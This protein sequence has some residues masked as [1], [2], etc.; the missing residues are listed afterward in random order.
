MPENDSDGYP[1]GLSFQ[2]TNNSKRV[3]VRIAGGGAVGQVAHSASDSPAD[4]RRISQTTRTKIVFSV[5]WAVYLVVS[6]GLATGVGI[7]IADNGDGARVFA[8]SG[9][10]P[11]SENG[12]AKGQGYVVTDFVAGSSRDPQKVINRI[13]TIHYP[14][15]N[16]Y[17]MTSLGVLSP[18]RTVSLFTVGW[19]YLII[20]LSIIWLVPLG[21]GLLPVGVIFGA[22]ALG[23]YARWVISTYADTPAF[24]GMAAVLSALV[25]GI[26]SVSAREFLQLNA[27][28]W[29]GSLLL[30][31]S[32]PAYGVSVPFVL[33]LW[34]VVLVVF[35]RGH[36]KHFLRIPLIL[37]TVA[38]LALTSLVSYL[39]FTSSDRDEAGRTNSYQFV[40]DVAMPYLPQ[41][42]IDEAIPANIQAMAPERYWPRAGGWLEVEGWQETFE[43]HSLINGLRLQVLS[44]PTTA[45]IIVSDTIVASTKPDISYTPPNTWS[46]PE[47]PP[48]AV[49]P[50]AL[51]QGSVVFVETLLIPMSFAT[52]NIVFIVVAALLALGLL[53][54][55]RRWKSGDGVSALAGQLTLLLWASGLFGGFFAGAAV[56]GDGYQEL[57]KHAILSSYMFVI[58]M[59]SLI[60]LIAVAVVAWWQ[61][62]KTPSMASPA[63]A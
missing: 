62:K 36:L 50:A 14:T 42:V 6:L 21:K 45:Y 39:Q 43:N 8:P 59:A 51:Y 55:V 46:T 5:V 1:S 32:K 35:H 18:D 49:V 4:S 31:L 26:R 33:I 56:L 9:V 24:F 54:L 44:Q 37:I 57:A 13:A 20:G 41:D 23:P 53:L 40:L 47:P 58:F 60:G 15:L 61:S 22:L 48:I 29:V 2:V 38:G 25:I 17:I 52:A 10:N 12:A 34:V 63:N 19:I 28:V 7:G 3:D 11:V 16:S 30:A 27:L